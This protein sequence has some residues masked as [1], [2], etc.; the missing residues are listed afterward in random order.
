MFKPDIKCDLCQK[1][2]KHQFE[3][4]GYVYH[5]AKVLPHFGLGS[6]FQT[7]YIRDEDI[8]YLCETCFEELFCKENP[9]EDPL[10]D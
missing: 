2:C 1:S 10:G 8:K 4:G 5:Y 6:K 3:D 7:T 9:K